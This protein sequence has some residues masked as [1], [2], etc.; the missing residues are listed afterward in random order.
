M[1]GNLK[2]VG[3]K[4]SGEYDFNKGIIDS[5][6]SVEEHVQNAEAMT[7]QNS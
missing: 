6:S 3:G 4:E 7:N 5:K 2:V 1:V